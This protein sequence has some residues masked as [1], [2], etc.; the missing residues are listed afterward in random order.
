MQKAMTTAMNRNI[1]NQIKL[2]KM[3]VDKQYKSEFCDI[4]LGDRVQLIQDVPDESVGFSIFSPP[5]AEL[6]TC[7]FSTN[8]RHGIEGLQKSSR[9]LSSG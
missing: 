2:N 4:R 9:R 8:S 6:Y 3:E 5:F 7:T 1:N